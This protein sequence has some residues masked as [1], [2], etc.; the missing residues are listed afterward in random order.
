[1]AKRI[2]FLIQGVH[3]AS[4]R[5]RVLNL[6]PELEKQGFE[7]DVVSYPKKKLARVRTFIG[8]RHYDIV[9]VQKKLFSSF[10]LF[11]LKVFG[12]KLVFDFD[13]AIY[14]S[15]D[16]FEREHHRRRYSRF[17]NMVKKSDLVT[18]G[19]RFL[20]DSVRPF[21]S[22]VMVI[23]SAVET[24]GVSV[25][26]HDRDNQT[27]VIGWVGGHVNLRYLELLGPVLRRLSRDYDIELRILCDR[28]IDIPDVKT[29][30]VLWSL[31]TQED[32][33][34]AFDIGVM[35]LTN[36]PHTS[37]KC[38]YKALQYMASG[39]PAVVSDVGGN[40][41]IVQN[42]VEGLVVDEIEGFYDALKLLIEDPGLRKKMGGR[43]RSK[44]EKFYSVEVVGKMLG[45][46]LSEF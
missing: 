14:C 38:G 6:L 42:K 20:A 21:N 34:A 11:L 43:A 7:P 30:H 18:A 3:L 2:L 16:E 13:D 10:N 33:I 17:E 22:H 44:V 4:S 23:P 15:R 31:D 25:A 32:E 19:N 36:D 28:S 40:R 29:R 39:V 37:G 27:V 45:R 24:R 12:K 9:V 26:L 8:S 1:V 35:P 41:E 5:V 46:A